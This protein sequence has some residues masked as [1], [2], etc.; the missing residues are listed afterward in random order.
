[1][2]CIDHLNFTNETCP[3]CAL[4]VDEYGN[5]ENRFDYCSYPNCGCDGARNCMAG[6]ASEDALQCNVEGMW[7]SGSKKKS[8]RGVFNTMDLVIK[9]SRKGGS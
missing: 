1:M 3:D 2:K 9:K 7:S 5:T 6:E 4:A 8:R